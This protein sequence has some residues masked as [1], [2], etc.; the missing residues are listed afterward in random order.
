[1]KKFHDMRTGYAK[2]KIYLFYNLVVMYTT[3]SKWNAL[4]ASVEWLICNKAGIFS[5][6]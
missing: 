1:M 2:Y 5:S 4:K 6:A 3:L